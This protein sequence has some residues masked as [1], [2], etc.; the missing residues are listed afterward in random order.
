VAWESC[1]T[2]STDQQLKAMSLD[3]AAVRQ[4]VNELTAKVQQMAGDIAAQQAILR[5]VSAP[6]PPALRRA[7]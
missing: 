5:R 6:P 3:L 7:N 2:R 4:S 1:G